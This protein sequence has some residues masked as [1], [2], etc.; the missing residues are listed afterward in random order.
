MLHEAAGTVVQTESCAGDAN[1]R[2]GA[3]QRVSDVKVQTE[4]RTKTTHAS[5]PTEEGKQKR[6]DLA[7]A[8]QH[9]MANPTSSWN[10]VARSFG[11]N[12]NTLKSHVNATEKGSSVRATGS[13]ATLTM[14]EENGIVV[15]A[16]FLARIRFPATKRMLLIKAKDIAHLV[17]YSVKELALTQNC[18]GRTEI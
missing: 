7:A 9:K 1:V 16:I 14:A 2:P 17:S 12:K 4:P 5:S 8:V 11:V 15:W 18:S 10:E 6:A 13:K 3:A